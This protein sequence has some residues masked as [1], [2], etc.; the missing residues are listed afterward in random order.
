MAA[1]LMAGD[2]LGITVVYLLVAA[3]LLVA[4]DIVCYAVLLVCLLAPGVA[5]GARSGLPLGMS[6]WLPIILVAIAK[7]L[8]PSISM[9]RRT[10][11]EEWRFFVVVAVFV[12]TA[13]IVA[14]VVQ[15][16][17]RRVDAAFGHREK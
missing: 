15:L 17:M 4:T 13:A 11:W 1:S 12:G 14:V 7:Y 9:A 5:A 3:R 8:E 10:G 16:M 2:A 6:F